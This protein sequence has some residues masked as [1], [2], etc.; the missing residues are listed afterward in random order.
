MIFSCFIQKLKENV[1]GLLRGGGGGGAKGM[2]PP[3]PIIGVGGCPPLPTPMCIGKRLDCGPVNAI[4]NFSNKFHCR[5]CILRDVHV[6]VCIF[7]NVA[8][9]RF[10]CTVVSR[11]EES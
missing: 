4:T 11:E 8:R 7:Y 2:L 10:V 6:N 1:T 9:R 5:F 3:P